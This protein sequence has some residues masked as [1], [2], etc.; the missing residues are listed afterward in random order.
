MLKHF[1]A[2]ALA[3]GLAMSA[4]QAGAVTITK[5]VDFSATG[6]TGAPG[7]TPTDPVTG[8]FLITLDTTQDYTNDTAD[9]QLLS[10]NIDLGSTLSFNYSTTGAYAGWLYVG[11]L[12]LGPDFVQ[13][14]SNDFYLQ[15][16]DFG[17]SPSFN[18]LGYTK[19]NGDYYYTTSPTS[20]SVTLTDPVPE[21]AAWAL[22]LLGFGGLG[23][24][25]RRSRRVRPSDQALLR[26]L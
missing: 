13:F 7:V 9:I 19:A 17:T 5:I 4:G 18:Q 16:A 26:P 23:S 24:A 12:Q 6:F 22:M 2:A 14:F 15:L 11:G 3:A 21:P 1:G 8:S 20:G 25:L 10:L